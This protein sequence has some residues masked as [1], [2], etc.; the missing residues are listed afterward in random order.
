MLNINIEQLAWDLINTIEKSDKEL[1][2]GDRSVEEDEAID[3]LK[4]GLK[5]LPLYATCYTPFIGTGSK[6][7]LS[8]Y[9]DEV[10]CIAVVFSDGQCIAELSCDKDGNERGFILVNI[11]ELSPWKKVDSVK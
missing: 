9:K 5:N 1:G 4:N 3:A 7:N 11:D 2:I 8:Q 6:W 10:V